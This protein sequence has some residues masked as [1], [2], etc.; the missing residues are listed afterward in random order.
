MDANCDYGNN[1]VNDCDEEDDRNVTCQP[2]TEE[3]S[4][5][6]A[7]AQRVTECPGRALDQVDVQTVSVVT[8]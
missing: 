6:D 4:E 5:V 2:T 7:A 3:P 1:V 8:L